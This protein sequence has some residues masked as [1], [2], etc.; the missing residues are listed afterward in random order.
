MT[1]NE[2]IVKYLSAKA[3][4]SLTSRQAKARFGVQNLRARVCELRDA[5][6][7]IRTQA[8]VNSKGR[9]AWRYRLGGV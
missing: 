5:G 3:D 2:R 9:T 4:R 8:T 6:F 1:Q 7:Y